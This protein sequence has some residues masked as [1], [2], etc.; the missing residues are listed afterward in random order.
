MSLGSIYE[1]SGG[2]TGR[3]LVF[4]VQVPPKAIGRAGGVLVE[5]PDRLVV[6]N[7]FER[8]ERVQLAQEKPGTL[9][10]H[11]P[12]SFVSGSALR[13]RGYGEGH[14]QGRPGDLY[15]KVQ[16]VAGASLVLLPKDGALASWP[17]LAEPKSLGLIFL[18]VVASVLAALSLL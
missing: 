7:G 8:A 14:P 16:I 12:E 18:G 4:E 17:A 10:L 11:L 5:L 3:D 9:R 6:R 1:S 13:L 2:P 15:L